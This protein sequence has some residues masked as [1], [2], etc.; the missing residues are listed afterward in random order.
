MKKVFLVISILLLLVSGFSSGA[1]EELE[2]TPFFL[3]FI[4]NIQFSPIYVGI[5]KGYFPDEGFDLQIEH[6]DENVGVEQIAAGT[7]DFGIISGEQVILARVGERPVVYVYEWFQQY[8]IGVLITDQLAATS[9]TELEDQAIGVPGRFGATYT[10]LT[11]M[12]S[13]NDMTEMDVEV[14]EIGFFAPDV[15]CSGNINAAT[16]YMNNEPIQIQNRIDSGECGDVGA[17]TV[18]PV[19][20]TIDMVS[21]GIVTNEMTL[22]ESPERVTALLRAFELALQDTINN[23]AEAY[24]LSLPYVDNLPASDEL[25]ATLTEAASAQDEFLATN[26]T[27]EEI[28]QSHDELFEQLLSEFELAELQQFQ[29]LLATIELWTGDALGETNP[30]SWF[31]TALVL[32]DMGVLTEDAAFDGAY[33]NDLLPQVVDE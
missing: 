3:A 13:A 8:P 20:N 16:V 11:A 2:E 26:P 21:N 4:P 32:Q 6:G 23:P 27:A 22:Q 9:M 5:E 7:I 25:I 33:T 10:A 17:I 12:L 31:T 30:A 28:A 15:V 18:L 19:A 24:L 29:V 14:R 1:Q